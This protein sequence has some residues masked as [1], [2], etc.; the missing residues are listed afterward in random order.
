MWTWLWHWMEVRPMES[1][2]NSKSHQPCLSWLLLLRRTVQATMRDLTVRAADHPDM[3]SFFFLNRR[4]SDGGQRRNWMCLLDTEE[5]QHRSCL[6]LPKYSHKEVLHSKP[7]CYREVEGIVTHCFLT[8][9]RVF[10]QW[11]HKPVWD[12]V[13]PPWANMQ[14]QR[15]TAPL[16]TVHTV[17]EGTKEGAWL[18]CLTAIW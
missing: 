10:C 8:K 1:W 12:I 7:I 2:A 17:G 14:T 16:G 13:L 9:P 3:T 11:G 4:P 15:A 18:V 5:W 6:I